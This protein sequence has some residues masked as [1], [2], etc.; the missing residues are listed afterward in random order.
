MTVNELIKNVGQLSVSDFE[1]FIQ[2]IEALR[3]TKLSP[4]KTPAQKILEKINTPFKRKKQLRF[5]FLIAKRDLESLNSAEY[6]ELLVLT[7]DFEEYELNRLKL[8]AKL[9]DLKKV[10]LPEILKMN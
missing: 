2:K 4:E 1:Y 9:A 3:A 8:I 10:S 7:E 5:N 6:Q